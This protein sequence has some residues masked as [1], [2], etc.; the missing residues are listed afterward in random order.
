[1]II[2]ICDGYDDDD[3]DYEDEDDAY[4]RIEVMRII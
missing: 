2:F 1:M 3:E 4:W